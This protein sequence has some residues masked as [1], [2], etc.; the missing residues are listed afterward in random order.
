MSP[1]CKLAVIDPAVGGLARVA[2]I[3]ANK[4]VFQPRPG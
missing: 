1:R 4:G 2:S 3:D